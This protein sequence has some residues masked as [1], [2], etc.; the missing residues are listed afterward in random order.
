MIEFTGYRLY[1]YSAP[2]YNWDATIILLRNGSPV[3]SL[4]FMKVGQPIPAN[5]SQSGQVRIHYSSIHLPNILNILRNEKPL[6]VSV[7]EGNKIGTISTTDEPIGEEE[8][9]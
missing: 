1:Y 9:D 2:Q 4:V 6:F 3:A 7:V 8:P 5:L